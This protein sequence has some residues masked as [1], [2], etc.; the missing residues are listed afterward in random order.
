MRKITRCGSAANHKK[1]IAE[2]VDN[3]QQRKRVFTDPHDGSPEGRERERRSRC[4]TAKSSTAKSRARRVSEEQQFTT[5]VSLSDPRSRPP[6]R[7]L[8][9]RAPYSYMKPS[10]DDSE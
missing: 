2:A 9:S 4:N 10:S 6:S 7:V 3:L 8:S 1:L 5:T